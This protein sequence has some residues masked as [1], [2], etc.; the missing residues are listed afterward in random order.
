MGGIRYRLAFRKKPQNGGVVCTYVHT[1]DPKF[2]VKAVRVGG[3]VAVNSADDLIPSPGFE[4]YA[5]KE[6]NSWWPVVGFNGKVE[7]LQDD[8]TSR[9]LA[10]SDINFVTP[11]GKLLLR[12]VGF[13]RR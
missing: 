11:K 1:V 3:S 5:P 6:E 12:V 13:T 8:G 2:A 9:P 4:V 10:L 7:V